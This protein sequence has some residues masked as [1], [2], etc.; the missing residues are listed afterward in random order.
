M[1]QEGH[2]LMNYTSEIIDLILEALP[3]NLIITDSD[4]IIQHANDPLLQLFKYKKKELIGQPVEVLIPPKL[5]ENHINLRNKYLEDPVKKRCFGATLPL[6]AIAKDGEELM[7]D[8]MLCPAKK[9]GAV[10]VIVSVKNVRREFVNMQKI[11]SALDELEK[12]TYK[13]INHH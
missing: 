2:T 8:I 1:F 12:M 11:K 7:V 6:R 5:R 3:E 9:S 10:I 13:L 4:G